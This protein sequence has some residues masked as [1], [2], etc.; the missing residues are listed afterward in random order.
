MNK[1]AQ[2]RWVLWIWDD[3]KNFANAYLFI[4]SGII[5]NSPCKAK[6]NLE[7]NL[8][9]TRDPVGGDSERD[10]LSQK[11]LHK[12]F[13]NLSFPYTCCIFLHQ[14]IRKKRWKNRKREE[15]CTKKNTERHMRQPRWPNVW[16]QY[17]KGWVAA[18]C[19]HVQLPSRSR[20]VTPLFSQDLLPLTLGH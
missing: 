7:K 5:Q 13:R 19:P 8:S 9:D 10:I 18:V 6:E 14:I 1:K 11:K 16:F 4:I 17:R 15:Y 2:R 12:H 20:L 3:H